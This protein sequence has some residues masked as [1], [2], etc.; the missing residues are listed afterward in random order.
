LH[1]RRYLRLDQLL[2][3]SRYERIATYVQTTEIETITEEVIP[4]AVGR[5]GE[6]CDV[7]VTDVQLLKFVPQFFTHPFG[8]EDGW[9]AKH[10]VPHLE[11]AHDA[12]SVEARQSMCSKLSVAEVDISQARM[13]MQIE[14][15][16]RIGVSTA[17]AIVAEVETHQGYQPSQMNHRGCCEAIGAEVEYLYS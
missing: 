7:V 10:V 12:Q 14:A 15:H 2:K 1:S 8:I 5:I 13:I 9:A 3:A 17:Q 16:I 6:E 4:V 11:S